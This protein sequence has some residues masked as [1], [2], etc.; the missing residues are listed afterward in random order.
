MN[1]SD[2]RELDY[3]ALS[4]T[5]SHALR[6]QP[7][8]YEL[9]LDDEGWVPLTS[10]L[11][12][13]R[14][15]RRQWRQLRVEDL[16]E[17]MRRSEKQRFEMHDGRFRALYGHS[18]PGHLLKEREEPPPLL[19]HG[20]RPE[21]L[22]AIRSGGLQP[23][24]RQYVHLSLDRSTALQVARRRTGRPVILLVRAAEAYRQGTAFYRGNDLVWLADYV[25]PEY[26]QEEA[27]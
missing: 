5:I 14:D 4:R 7:W 26:I 24:N 9:E 22:A 23:M 15:E 10:L 6:H 1:K 18:V 11:E 21:V 12:A 17:M 19:Y 16:E 2:A 25:L 20:T 3:V 13:L 27:G 8:L